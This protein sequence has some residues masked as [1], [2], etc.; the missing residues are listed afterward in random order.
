MVLNPSNS[1][2][3]EQLALKALIVAK[4]KLLVVHTFVDSLKLLAQW[5]C[6]TLLAVCWRIMLAGF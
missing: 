5:K 4:N 1:S 2:S 6:F 3:V